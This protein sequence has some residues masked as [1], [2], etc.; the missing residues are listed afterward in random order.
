MAEGAGVECQA[1][2]VFVGRHWGPLAMVLFLPVSLIQLWVIRAGE[3]MH[4]DPGMCHI[5]GSCPQMGNQLVDVTALD[6]ASRSPPALLVRS[7]G[8]LM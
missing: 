5:L 3:R 8:V 1:E 7:D 2:I 6:A 4:C